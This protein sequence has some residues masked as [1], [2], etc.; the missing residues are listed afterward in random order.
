[1]IIFL[2]KSLKNV[3]GF[4][5]MSVSEK[6]QYFLEVD[7]EDPDELHELHNYYSLAP[8]KLAV[9]S[10]MLPK[11]CKTIADKYEIKVGDVRKLIPNLGNKTKYYF[12]TKIFKNLYL[13]L[14][15]KLIK[16]HR[17]LKFK[18]S[19]WM[20]KYIDFNTKKQLNAA[21]DFEKDFLKLMINSVYGK[22]MENLRKKISVGLVT[23]EKDFL[24]YTSKP[25]HIAH[26][27]FDKNVAAIHEIKSVLILNKPIY[28]GFTVLE[29]SKWL[30]Y[31]FHYNFIKKN[32]DAELL[33]TNTDS[34]TYEVKSEDFYEE[35]FKWKD[36]FDFSNYLEDS[37]F[38]DDTNKKVIGKMKDEFGGVIVGELVGL[39]QKCIL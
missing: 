32:S 2:F 10:D 27:M 12:T 7:L 26:K 36:L 29:L 13:S 21:N 4:D 8:E 14:G 20:K 28:V 37:K 39:N 38:F 3:D 24:K 25:T 5:V 35:F 15:M 18:Q 22:T 31:K 33:F 19:D 6:V 34:P 16:I 11:Y 9:S 30:M 1:M 17:T 23:N